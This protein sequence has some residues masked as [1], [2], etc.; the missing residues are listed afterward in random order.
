MTTEKEINAAIFQLVLDQVVD[1]LK[2]QF[3][4][5]NESGKEISMCPQCAWVDGGINFNSPT[6]GDDYDVICP[7][8]YASENNGTEFIDFEDERDEWLRSS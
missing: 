4:T 8:C 1:K 6:G 7:N 5:A 2:A 3:K